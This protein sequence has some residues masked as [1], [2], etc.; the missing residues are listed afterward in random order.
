M[1]KIRLRKRFILSVIALVGYLG[2]L[3]YED[4]IKQ[5][6]LFLQSKKVE[7]DETLYKRIDELLPK[8]KT[9]DS[10]PTTEYINPTPPIIIPETPIILPDP[11]PAIPA[12]PA[13]EQPKGHWVKK[14]CNFCK[15]TGKDPFR[16]YAPRYGTTPHNVWCSLCN[17]YYE[18]HYHE[19][20]PSC[21]GKGYQEDYEY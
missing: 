9:K 3:V 14:T 1:S 16:T 13:S 4:H 17:G 19:R 8:Q 15:G 7:I 20:C 12:M 5:Q 18:P 6:D 21:N 10:N 2:Y 11:I